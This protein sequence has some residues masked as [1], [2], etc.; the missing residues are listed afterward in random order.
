MAHR[1]GGGQDVLAKHS[2]ELTD[3]KIIE[4]ARINLRHVERWGRWWAVFHWTIAIAYV[5]LFVWVCNLVLGG[6]TIS[7]RIGP[8][9]G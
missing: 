9:Y 5:V 3:A 8:I 2:K 7:P 6:E 1:K 4:R